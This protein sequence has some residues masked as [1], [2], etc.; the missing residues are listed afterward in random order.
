MIRRTRPV[1][2]GTR[3]TVRRLTKPMS[4]VTRLLLGDSPAGRDGGDAV[5]GRRR[6]VLHPQPDAAQ[7]P[8]PGAAHRGGLRHPARSRHERPGPAPGGGGAHLLVDRAVRRPRRPPARGVP[9]RRGHDRPR[10]HHLRGPSGAAGRAGG[11]GDAAHRRPPAAAHRHR[12]DGR[13]RRRRARA[14]LRAQ[15][16]AAAGAGAGHRLPRRRRHLLGAGPSLPGVRP[17]H[18]EP[19]RD[20]YRP[21]DRP[22]AATQGRLGRASSRACPSR[23]RSGS[24]SRPR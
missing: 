12:D 9:R 10:A 15:G 2:R 22:A 18:R 8:R 17:R 1:C 3:S 24:V 21:A 6:G 7:P 11:T 16:P 19:L 14:G 4:I 5:H 23:W 20:L 13:G